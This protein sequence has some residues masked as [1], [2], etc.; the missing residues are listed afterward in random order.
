MANFAASVLDWC[1]FKLTVFVTLGIPGRGSKLLPLALRLPVRPL[2][3]ER[4][5]G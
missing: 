2:V 5:I 3:G 4:V 1:I